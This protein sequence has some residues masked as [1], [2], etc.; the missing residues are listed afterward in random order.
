[1]D[2]LT[3]KSADSSS[4]E[5]NRTL[6]QFRLDL[7]ITLPHDPSAGRIKH[8]WEFVGFYVGEWY[9]KMTVVMDGC[10]SSI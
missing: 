3:G 7:P 4:V 8:L 2:N 5:Y 1:M 9:L 10:T 6:L